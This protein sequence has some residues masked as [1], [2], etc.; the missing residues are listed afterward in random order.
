M[1]NRRSKQFMKLTE[2]QCTVGSKQPLVCG[3]SN[4]NSNGSTAGCVCVC[5]CV[6]AVR[7]VVGRPLCVWAQTRPAASNAGAARRSTL[8]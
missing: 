7:A 6:A 1:T 8:S 2:Q 3:N 5:V 4:S